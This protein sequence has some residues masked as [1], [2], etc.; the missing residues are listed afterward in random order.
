MWPSAAGPQ[1]QKWL[2]SIELRAYFPQPKLKILNIN[3]FMGLYN[4]EYFFGWHVS[5]SNIQNTFDKTIR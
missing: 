1:K 2:S 3:K 5:I 4:F